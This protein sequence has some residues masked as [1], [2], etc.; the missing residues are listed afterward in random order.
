MDAE[1]EPEG[2]A[3]RAGG[4]R[5][6]GGPIDPQKSENGLCR[7]EHSVL[8]AISD[9]FLGRLDKPVIGKFPAELRGDKTTV[10]YFLPGH[11]DKV[12]TVEQDAQ[13]FFCHQL[14]SGFPDIDSILGSPVWI[15]IRP[16]GDFRQTVDE[17]FIGF[18]TVPDHRSVRNADPT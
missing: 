12:F 7:Y 16:G 9:R 5:D 1:R 14:S 8:I 17:A 10:G 18:M 11:D 4:A 13:V 2:G 3:K 6:T 15:P